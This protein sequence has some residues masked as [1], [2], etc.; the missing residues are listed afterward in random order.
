[1]Q[2]NDEELVAHCILMRN[3]Y[4]FA[5]LINGFTSD[6]TADGWVFCCAAET[7]TDRAATVTGTVTSVVTAPPHPH[8]LSL[9]EREDWISKCKAYDNKD[10]KNSIIFG[11][12]SY[13]V[14]NY[15]VQYVHGHNIMETPYFNVQGRIQPFDGGSWIRLN[16]GLKVLRGIPTAS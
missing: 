4:N 2:Q 13:C 1:M 12:Q 9:K 14:Q 7:R 8:H 10:N 3:H 16:M 6:R 15:F 11:W 5:I